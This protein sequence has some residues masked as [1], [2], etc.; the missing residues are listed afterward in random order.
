V[1]DVETHEHCDVLVIAPTFG[2]AI[3][4]TNAER[5][6]YIRVGLVVIQRVDINK[7]K[8]VSTSFDSD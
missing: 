8:G 5:S 3:I 1:F 4:C 6:E 7:T 2:I